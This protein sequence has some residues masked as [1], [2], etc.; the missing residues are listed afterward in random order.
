MTPDSIDAWIEIATL[1]LSHGAKARV[2]AEVRAH[3]EQ[4]LEAALAGGI[5]HDAAHAA[6]LAALGPASKARTRFYKAFLTTI[7]E[8]FI[9]ILNGKLPLVDVPKPWWPIDWAI[10]FVVALFMLS[11]SLITATTLAPNS[12]E[13]L[14]RYFMRDRP[15]SEVWRCIGIIQLLFIP[16]DCLKLAYR[17]GAP[18]AAALSIF[19]IARAVLTLGFMLMFASISLRIASKLPKDK[20]PVQS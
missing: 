10:Y 7:E 4:A 13:R 11:G 12:W 8:E 19:E 2:I 3:Y 1:D 14:V 9:K 6:A 18:D 15:Q 20:G 5:D 16:L 17:A